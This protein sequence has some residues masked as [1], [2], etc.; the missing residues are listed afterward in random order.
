MLCKQHSLTSL[1]FSSFFL[2]WRSSPDWARA[3]SLS[4]FHDHTQTHLDEWPARLRDLYLITHN[5]HRRQ[6]FMLPAGIRTHISSKWVAAEPSRR[7]RG[8]WDRPIIFLVYKNVRT[9]R[10]EFPF[11]SKIN[12][13]LCSQNPLD[14]ILNHF[15]PV[16]IFIL[17]CVYTN[18][19]LYSQVSF[20]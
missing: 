17:N 2:P 3:P 15:Y 1:L 16:H 5:T 8:Y 11:M 9:G 7:P 19:M 4:R 18:C 14:S 6:I 12:F 13:L 10:N 20:T